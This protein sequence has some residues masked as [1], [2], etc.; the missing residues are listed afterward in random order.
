MRERTIDPA[1]HHLYH[2]LEE[3]LGAPE[4]PAGILTIEHGGLPLDVRYDPRGAS[5]TLVVFNAALGSPN[6]VHPAFM[7]D[8]ISADLDINRIF[9][10]DPTL[11]L[12]D[13]LAVAWYAGNRFQ[14]LQQV[15]PRVI[16]KLAGPEQRVILF[17]PSGGGFAALYFASTLA[18][19]LA[20]PVNPQTSIKAYGPKGSGMYA[21]AAFGFVG[22]D[23]ID[24]VP[25]TTDLVE[26]YSAPVDCRV[27]YVQNTG[28]RGHVINHMRP[29][30]DRLDP[31]NSVQS[32]TLYAGDGH[33][34][35]PKDVL[36]RILRCAARGDTTPPKV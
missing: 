11:Y 15:I 29:F 30:L 4:P 18:G 10:A 26:L 23:A 6:T 35:P 33:K 22:E 14:G 34:A 7:G 8:N 12:D 16:R 21:E 36:V 31:S 1:V 32:V 25:V 9:I 19:S 3:F 5:T 20:I 28:D 2:S 17:G 27:W 13:T 24:A